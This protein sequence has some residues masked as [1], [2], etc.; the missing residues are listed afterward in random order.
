MPTTKMR[1]VVGTLDL[2]KIEVKTTAGV[3]EFEAR[4]DL[5]TL[6]GEVIGPLWKR[7]NLP[8][9]PEKHP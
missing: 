4:R 9:G 1:N 2:G 6:P 7:P 3:L 8:S 5:R